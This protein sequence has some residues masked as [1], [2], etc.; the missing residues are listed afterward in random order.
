[1]ALSEKSVSIAFLQKKQY[2]KRRKEELEPKKDNNGI[3]IYKFKEMPNEIIISK[4]HCNEF[5]FGECG[6]YYVCK[7]LGWQRKEVVDFVR[8]YTKTLRLAIYDNVDKIKFDEKNEI[9]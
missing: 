6:C 1:M 5:N 7:L 8:N 3:D 4:I 2:F 9:E